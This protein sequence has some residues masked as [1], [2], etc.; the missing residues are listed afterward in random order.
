MEE[1]IARICALLRRPENPLSLISNTVNL[2]HGTR[3]REVRVDGVVVDVSRRETDVLEQLLRRARGVIPKDV[4]E[5]KIYGFDEEVSSN[6]REAHIFRLRKRI[7]DV[8]AAVEIKTRRGIGNIIS[9]IRTMVPETP[10]SQCP[11]K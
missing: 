4:L 5:E 8:G 10:P 1:L 11:L 9:E 6:S 7:L 3:N 2:E